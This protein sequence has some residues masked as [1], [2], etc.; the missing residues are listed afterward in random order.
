MPKKD[1]TSPHDATFFASQRVGSI[2]ADNVKTIAI[3]RNLF[4]IIPSVRDWITLRH[5][6]RFLKLHLV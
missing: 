3:F 2:P 6:F 4:G 1:Q 5:C